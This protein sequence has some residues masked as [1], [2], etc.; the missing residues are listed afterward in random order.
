MLGA[1]LMAPQASSLIQPLIDAVARGLSA[2]D[3]ATTQMWIHPA[4]MELIEN[5]LLGVA[6]VAT[7]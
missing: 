6:E 5:A 3:V 4:A 7:P 2:R 1:Q